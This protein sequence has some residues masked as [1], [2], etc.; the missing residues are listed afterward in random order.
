[1][2][3]ETAK[4]QVIEALKRNIDLYNRDE[5]LGLNEGFDDFLATYPRESKSLRIAAEFWEAWSD[6]AEHGYPG[7]YETINESDWPQLAQE[8]ITKLKKVP[9]TAGTGC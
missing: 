3:E 5:I 1:M 8:I 2:S 9:G 7:F 6:E 4:N